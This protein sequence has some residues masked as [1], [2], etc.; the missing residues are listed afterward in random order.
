LKLNED[1]AEA[2]RWDKEQ[3]DKR[4]EK[5]VDNALLLFKLQEDVT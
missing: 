1:L 5:L 4:T 2:D 3:I